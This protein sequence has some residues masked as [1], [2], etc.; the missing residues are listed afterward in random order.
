MKVQTLAMATGRGRPTPLVSKNKKVR[1]W[2]RRLRHASNARVIE[3]SILVYGIEIEGNEYD[4]TKIFIDSD[5]KDDENTLDTPIVS[6][7]DAPSELAAY[8][9]K[10]NSDFNHI[11]DPCAGSKSTRVVIWNKSMASTKKMLE[12][13]HADL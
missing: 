13:V 10:K 11:C 7:P 4:P 5:T 2:H 12:E 1:I 8:A 3:A 9:S 6:D